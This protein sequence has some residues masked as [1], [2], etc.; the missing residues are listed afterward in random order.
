MKM[1]VHEF[2]CESCIRGYHIYKDIWNSTIGEHLICE[3]ETLNSTDR[4]AVA[5]LK[6][7]IIIG[8]LPRVLSRIC[9]L[10]IVRGGTITCV[11][12]GARRYSADLPQGGLE[13]P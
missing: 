2:E 4:Y 11:V 7:D 12:N 1:A 6:D 3:R 10:F 13:V 5:V 9:S 8:H